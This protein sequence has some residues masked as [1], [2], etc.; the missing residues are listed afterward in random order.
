[1]PEIKET[2]IIGPPGTGKTTYLSRQIGLAAEKHGG[3]AVLV[4]SFAKASAQEL[5]GRNLAIPKTNVG[6]LHSHCYR[7]LDCKKVAETE[8]KEFNREYPDYAI[9]EVRLKADDDVEDMEEPP[10]ETPEKTKGDELYSYSQLLRAGCT[11]LDVWPKEVREFHQAWTDW[12]DGNSLIDFTGLIETCVEQTECAPG[13]PSVIFVDEAQDLSRLE[14][15]LIRKWGHHAEHLVLAGDPWQCIY[16]FKGA[17]PMVMDGTPLPKEHRP[18]LHQSYRVSKAVHATAMRF[19]R[20]MPDYEPI[21]YLPT[22]EQGSISCNFAT[23]KNPDDAI[24][25]AERFIDR[26][27]SVM[28]LGS[29]SYMLEPLKHELRNRALPFWNPYRKKRGDWNPLQ[30]RKGVSASNRVLSFLS[31]RLNG[32]WTMAEA[33][34]WVEPLADVIFRKGVKKMI[35][36]WIVDKDGDGFVP[37]PD[38]AE[39]SNWFRS[40]A[41]AERALGRDLNWYRDHLLSS[42]IRPLE[43]VIEIVDRGGVG[44]L[45]E[46]PKI[47]LGSIHSVKGGQADHVFL[48]PDISREARD[49]AETSDYSLAESFRLFYVAI[50]RARSSVTL[51]AD[52]GRPM[53]FLPGVFY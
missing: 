16:S 40:P 14:M 22:E 9:R 53:S 1:M 21:E 48:F 36:D 15:R 50:T 13:G 3:D 7:T 52:A 11:P 37:D 17:D 28:F 42:K 12:K 26:G 33:Q 44:S 29:C 24:S 35:K 4:T 39:C 8:I 23:W 18:I 30:P 27:E 20:Q 19:M 2:R 43:Y 49:S 46:Q 31:Q 41:H 10:W 25:A 32:G 38:A 51:C 34:K 45:T 6:T 47:I 5:V